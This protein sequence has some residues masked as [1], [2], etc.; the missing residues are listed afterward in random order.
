ME[1]KWLSVAPFSVASLIAKKA[2][3]A[4]HLSIANPFPDFIEAA[5]PS[6]KC[7]AASTINAHRGFSAKFVIMPSAIEIING[8]NISTALSRKPG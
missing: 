7:A 5:R 8:L 4:S 3:R 1:N 2:S 6:H